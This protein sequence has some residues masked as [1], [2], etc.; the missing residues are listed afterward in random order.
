M[1]KLV[2]LENGQIL[3]RPKKLKTARKTQTKMIRK[4]N[5]K[6]ENVLILLAHQE[7]PQK[8]ITESLIAKKHKEIF[9]YERI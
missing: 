8:Y 6:P 7:I 4:N 2:N 9:G 1:Y 3:A 5:L